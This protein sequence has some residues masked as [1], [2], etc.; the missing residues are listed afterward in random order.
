MCT[1]GFLFSYF[2]CS[3]NRGPVTWLSTSRGPLGVLTRSVPDA[4]RVSTGQGFLSGFSSMKRPVIFLG[5]AASQGF[6]YKCPGDNN[7]VVL[8]RC[9]CKSGIWV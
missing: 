4:H 8:T 3:S 7:T 2:E 9:F 5:V 1:M 6:L